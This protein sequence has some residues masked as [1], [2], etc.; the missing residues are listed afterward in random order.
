MLAF[1]IVF[2][3][4]GAS[5]VLFAAAFRGLV[6]AVWSV[7]DWTATLAGGTLTLES[8]VNLKDKVATYPIAGGTGR[9][10]GALGTVSLTDAGKKGTLVTVRYER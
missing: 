4:H 2:L 6:L 5:L 8:A 7:G 1:A 10:A 3:L 9:Y